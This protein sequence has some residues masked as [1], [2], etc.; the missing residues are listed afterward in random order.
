MDPAKRRKTLIALAAIVIVIVATVGV[1]L[2]FR[3]GPDISVSVNTTLTKIQRGTSGTVQ[4]SLESKNSFSGVVSL[5]VDGLPA[6][7]RASFSSPA[8]QLA[9]GGMAGT[10]LTI[11]VG[12][13][14][15]GQN[16]TLTIAASGPGVTKG[17]SL[18]LS[19]VGTSYNFNMAGSYSGGWNV[20]SISVKEGD[21]I[22]LKLT[23]SDSLTHAFYVDY[24]GNGTPDPTEP[25]SANF[26][27]PN[28]PVPFSFTTT[29]VGTYTYYCKYHRN[30]T[31]S[32]HSS[33]P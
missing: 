19:V 21:I 20:T 24:N 7:V 18:L 22:N 26:N 15:F 11:S 17:A 31:G 3:F 14:A 32:F 29:Q 6:N 9:P 23:S 8:V 1:A 10:Q 33:S 12:S 27:S 30:M 16:S 28:T 4:V 2:F 5:T 25:L 13:Y